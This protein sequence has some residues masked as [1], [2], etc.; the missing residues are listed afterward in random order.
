MF[1]LRRNMLLNIGLTVVFIF[2]LFLMIW[3]FG[4]AMDRGKEED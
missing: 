1:L 2:L 4:R 3:R